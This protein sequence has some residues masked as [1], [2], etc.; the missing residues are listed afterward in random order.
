MVFK[1]VE[2]VWIFVVVVGNDFGVLVVRVVVDEV[3]RRMRNR[4]IGLIDIFN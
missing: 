2:I 1:F 3:V 4:S